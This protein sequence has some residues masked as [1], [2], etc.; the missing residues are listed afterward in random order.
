[1]PCD[2]LLFWLHRILHDF[3]DFEEIFRTVDLRNLPAFEDLSH[4]SDLVLRDALRR[5]CDGHPL[6]ARDP[7]RFN[8]DDP[9]T[10]DDAIL[11][12]QRI[13]QIS[14]AAEFT[15]YPVTYRTQDG[16]MLQV[17]RHTPAFLCPSE[18]GDEDDIKAWVLMYDDYY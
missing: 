9:T 5:H 4:Y 8:C 18:W 3:P 13:R 10:L 14:N 1:M 2:T 12:R 6:V 16:I 15:G 11:S 17:K 7:T